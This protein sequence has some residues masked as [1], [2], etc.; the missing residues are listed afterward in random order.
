MEN[1]R[2]IHLVHLQLINSSFLHKA[3]NVLVNVQQVK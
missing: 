3:E 1:G 2:R